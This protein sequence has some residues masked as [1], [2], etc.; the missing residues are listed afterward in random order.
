MVSDGEHDGVI[1]TRLGLAN[2]GDAVFMLGLG[3]IGDLQSKTQTGLRARAEPI[4]FNGKVFAKY[5]FTRGPVKNFSLGF[6]FEKNADRAGDGA[7][8]FTMPGYELASAFVAYRR[9]QWHAQINVENVLD[10]PYASIAVARQIIYAGEP[11]RAT[12][13]FGYSF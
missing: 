5:T 6:G 12:M 2:R 4:G 13:T 1:G 9:K 10:Q 7:D 8:T 11:R 3:G